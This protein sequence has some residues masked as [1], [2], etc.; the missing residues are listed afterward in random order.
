MVHSLLDDLVGDFILS[1]LLV[2]EVP[3]ACRFYGGHGGISLMLILSMKMTV[4]TRRKCKK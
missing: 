3:F 2:L 1:K 4:I